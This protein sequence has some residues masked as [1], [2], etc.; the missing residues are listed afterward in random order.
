MSIFAPNFLLKC[1]ISLSRVS[2]ACLSCSHNP[3]CS[4]MP[5]WRA[6]REHLVLA[7][8]FRVAHFRSVGLPEPCCRS[9]EGV[10]Y[11][12]KSWGEEKSF[13]HGP[14]EEEA[15]PWNGHHVSNVLVR[16]FFLP[17]GSCLPLDLGFALQPS[18]YLTMETVG[19]WYSNIH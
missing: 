13:Q 6:G 12:L 9:M 14:N 11:P 17:S 1:W 10:L 4:C 18:S 8:L 3:E 2:W 19:P 7:A 5:H 16:T 15:F